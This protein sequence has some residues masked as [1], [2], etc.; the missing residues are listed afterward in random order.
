MSG[1][2]GDYTLCT[3]YL[4]KEGIRTLLFTGVNTDQCVAGSL[5]DAYSRGYDCLM[6]SDGC[7][8]TSPQSSQDNLEYN[9]ARSYGFLLS[10]EDL[11]KGVENIEKS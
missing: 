1:L 8:T 4:E 5:M 11:A 9:A 10:C 3:K 7:A 6:L 2:W